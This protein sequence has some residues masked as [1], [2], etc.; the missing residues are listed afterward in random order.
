MSKRPILALLVFAAACSSTPAKP[1]TLAELPKINT[2]RILTDIK[3]LS[4]DEFEGRAP[5]TKGEQLTVAYLIDQFKAAGLEPGNPDGTWTQKVPLVG[6]TPDFTP[7]RREEGRDHAR[8]QHQSRRRRLQ[9]ARDRRGEARELRD[10]VRRLRRAGAR[11]QLGRLQGR[12][13]QG[14]DDRRA[15]Q[16]SA[17]DNAGEPASS[18]ERRSAARR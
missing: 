4:S 14:Q 3:K 1:L 18:T 7:L 17:G 10:R 15:R 2:D 11:V 13:R 6:L 9:Q 8:V 16:R 5:G 12:G